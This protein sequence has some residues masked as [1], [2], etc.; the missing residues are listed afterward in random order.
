M[1]GL[2]PPGGGGGGTA[3]LKVATHCKTTAPVF[4]SC[5]PLSFLVLSPIFGSF[6][7]SPSKIK[8]LN[9][10]LYTKMTPIFL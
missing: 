6:K 7:P 4:Q 1:K 9:V 3:S 10:K 5:L 2:T 8:L